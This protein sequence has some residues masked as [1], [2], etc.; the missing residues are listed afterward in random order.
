MD[1]YTENN[2]RLWRS[3]QIFEDVVKGLAFCKRSFERRGLR[4]DNPINQPPQPQSTMRI[5]TR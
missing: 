5:E 3:V 2:A 4:S 1:V